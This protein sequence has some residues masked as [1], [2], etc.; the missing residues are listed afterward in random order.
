MKAKFMLCAGLCWTLFQAQAAVSA[1]FSREIVIQ[2]A[3]RQALV[4][5]PLDPAI[6]KVSTGDFGDLRVTDQHGVETPYLLQKIASRKAVVHRIPLRSGKPALQTTGAEGILITIDLDQQAASAD[7]LT[8]HTRQR[9]FEYVLQVL[10]SEDGQQWTA[11]AENAL[12]YDYSRF[13]SVGSRDVKLPANTFKHFKIIVAQAID[14]RAAELMELTRTLRGDEEL[15]RNEKTEVRHQP[16]HIERIELWHNQTD[17]VA[18]AEQVFD[19][20]LAGFSLSQD[21]GQKT[22]VLD[23][24]AENQPLTGLQLDIATPIFSRQAEVQI[25]QKQGVESQNQTIG[26]GTLAALRFQEIAHSETALRF[27]QQRRQHYRVVIHNQDSPALEIKGVTGSGPGYQVLFINQ[28][29]HSYR[30]HYANDRAAVPRYD[31]EPIRELLRQG[32]QPALAVLGPETEAKA[33]DDQW[34]LAKWLN[35]KLFL[36]LAIGLMV[37]VLAWSLYKVGKRVGE[38][39]E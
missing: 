32:Y 39:S 38:A 13:M 18:D 1:R 31:I 16:L 29:G 11:L 23:I 5:V 22:S 15:Q 30:L 19:Y 21:V 27:P 35:S 12:I 14:T 8:V 28:P 10:G 33:L 34:H 20:A 17:S 4:A 36:G 26:S 37:V 25:E 9:D 7:G 6:Y 3:D 2:E 24:E